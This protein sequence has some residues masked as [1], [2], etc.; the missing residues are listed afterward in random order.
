MRW[1]QPPPSIL[2]RGTIRGDLAL[3]IGTNLI[4]GSDSDETAKREIGLF[5]SEGEVLEYARDVDRWI[6]EF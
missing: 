4:H 1:A 2:L 5:F 6:I 3:D